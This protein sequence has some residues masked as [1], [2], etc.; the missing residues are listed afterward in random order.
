ML[1]LSQT[2]DPG[3]P[4]QVRNTKA[5]NKNVQ[6]NAKYLAH[7]QRVFRRI[8]MKPEPILQQDEMHLAQIEDDIDV[9]MVLP[10]HGC[11]RAHNQ[12]H[13]DKKCCTLGVLLLII[14]TSAIQNQACCGCFASELGNTR[15]NQGLRCML[16]RL[17]SNHE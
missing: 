9:G 4:C 10:R 11:I 15:A 12:V 6:K 13:R 5:R 16:G 2:M 17:G 7:V 1:V 3:H 14:S 8:G